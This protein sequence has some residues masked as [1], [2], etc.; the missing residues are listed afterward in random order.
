MKK[1][2]MRY[3]MY[4]LAVIIGLA[5]SGCGS[6]SAVNIRTDNNVSSVIAGGTLRLSASGRGISWSISSTSDGSGSLAAGT[7]ISEAGVLTVSANETALIIY[8]FAV[9][10]ETDQSAVR[11]IR[12]VRVNSVSITPANQTVAAGRTLQFRA[13]VTGVNNPDNAV[14]WRVYSNAAGTGAVTQGTSINNS[15]MLTVAPSEAARTLYIFGTSLVDPRVSGS[16]PVTVVVPTVTSVSVYPANQTITAGAS[17]QF[18]AAVAGTYDPDTTVTWTVSSNPAGTGVVTPGTTIGQNGVLTIASNESLSLLYVR[19][20]STVD[21]SRF[22]SV[23]VTVVRPVVTAVSVAPT[24]LSIPAGS[25]VQFLATVVGQNNP[26]T[27]VTW[28]VSSNAAGTGAVTPGTSIDSN[29]LLTIAANETT[30]TLFIFATSVFDPAQSGTAIITVTIPAGQPPTE[31][32]P[33]GQPPT[34]RPPTGQPPTGRPPTGQPPTGRPPT[35][36]PPTEQPPTE[37]PPSVQPP[38]DQPP[39]EQPPTIIVTGVIVNPSSQTIRR[40]NTFQFT[41]TVAGYPNPNP[42]LSW[43]V[44][45][46]SN[47][48]GAVSS[49]TS[50]TGNGLLRIGANETATTLYVV[51]IYNPDTS[52]FGSAVITI[53]P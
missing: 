46:N 48:T 29:G 13:S 33:T 25:A 2:A 17:L 11:Q 1:L 31:Q 27:T 36:R 34:G 51:A 23:S 28:R 12:V 3:S 18:S 4:I 14:T 44:G 50:I 9:S 52:R 20:T 10:S 53:T 37:Q 7:S 6:M 26:D 21:P 39:T 40:G 45:P 41:A 15:G 30:T 22:G 16:V 24:N 19:A 43:R 49:G 35:G 47:G 5:I 32:P 42:P 38:A 8:V